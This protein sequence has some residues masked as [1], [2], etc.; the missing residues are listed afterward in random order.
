MFYGCLLPANR[1]LSS[2]PEYTCPLYILSR[3]MVE[4]DGRLPSDLLGVKRIL[5]QQKD[6]Y[7]SGVHFGRDE[8]PKHD[9]SCY[10]SRSVGQLID[11]L[12]PLSHEASL[13]TPCAKMLEHLTERPL[14]NPNRQIAVLTKFRPLSHANRLLLLFSG[15]T[16][17]GRESSEYGSL[18]RALTPACGSQAS[19]LYSYE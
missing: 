5:H 11:A 15:L 10:L 14:M 7:I 3:Q 18:Y 16:F 1:R 2:N 12:Q 9:K 17:N 13:E 8:G 4:N 19:V 6:V